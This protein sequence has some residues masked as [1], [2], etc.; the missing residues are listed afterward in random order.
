MVDP[1]AHLDGILPDPVLHVLGPRRL[2]LLLAD[3]T[4]RIAQHRIVRSSD[5]RL[6]GPLLRGIAILPDRPL[7]GGFTLCGNL[8]VS[9]LAGFDPIPLVNVP[10]ASL[11]P[12]GGLRH[13]LVGVEMP[14]QVPGFLFSALLG[15]DE[16]TSASSTPIRF[17]L[18]EGRN[19]RYPRAKSRCERLQKQ[20]N[21]SIVKGPTFSLTRWSWGL[22]T[23]T[24]LMGWVVG[25]RGL[26][27]WPVNDRG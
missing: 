10:A 4:R 23:K 13:A 26:E 6:R 15:G 20:Q 11:C 5:P 22:G 14:V 21:R 25:L 24:S 3:G 19:E 7:G 17:R 16:A 8:V 1:R 9:H 2:E 27:A 12:L 18:V